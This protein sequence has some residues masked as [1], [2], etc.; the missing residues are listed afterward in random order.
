MYRRSDLQ[1]LQDIF[2]RSSNEMAVL[3]GSVENDLSE[4]VS[5]FIKDKE[6]LYYRAGD[7]CYSVQ[8]ELFAFELHEQTR[9]PVFPDDDYEK[10]ISSFTDGHSDKKKLIVFADFQYLVKNDPTLVNF[11]TDRMFDKSRPGS[12]MYLLVSDDISWVENDMIRIIGRKSYEIAGVIKLRDHTPREFGALFPKMP[13]SNV[14]GIYSI[15]GGK[16]RYYNTLSDSSTVRDV[17]ITLLG[18]Y[19]DPFFDTERYLPRDIREP[20][21]YNSILVHLASGNGKLGDIHDATL[22]DRAKLSVYIRKLTDSGMIHKAGTAFYRISDPFVKFY[23]RFVYTHM[24]SLKILGPDR[25]YRR[26]IEHELQTFIGEMFPV[27]CMEQIRW[28]QSENRL[29]FK[30]VSVEEY[31]DRNGAI[32]FIIVAAGGSVIACACRY[33][34]PHMSYRTYEEVRS[35]VRRKKLICDNIWLFSASGFDQKLTMFGSVTPGVKLID[36]SEHRL[37]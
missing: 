9:S 15:I 35:T 27:F 34:G 19:S 6:C 24:S 4:L 29:N 16:S 5:D 14:I 21:L 12:V 20:E 11:L 17:I 1:Y 3:Y 7:V 23:Y 10:L 13:V 36:A 18:Q 26:Y 25:F 32:D 22:V 37:H 2:D 31:P 28:L 8:K 33:E 30:A